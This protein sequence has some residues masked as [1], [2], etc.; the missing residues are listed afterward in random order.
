MIGYFL[1]RQHSLFWSNLTSRKFILMFESLA[2]KLLP[3][4]LH[5]NTADGR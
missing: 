3:L 2:F 5:N 4:A 1:M